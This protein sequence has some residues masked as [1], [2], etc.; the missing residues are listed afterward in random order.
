MSGRV[1]LRSSEFSAVPRN[2]LTGWRPPSRELLTGFAAACD[3]SEE[4]TRALLAARA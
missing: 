1:D 4:T 3:A 2:A